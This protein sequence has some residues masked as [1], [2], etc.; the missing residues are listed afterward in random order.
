MTPADQS[1]P[2]V[3]TDGPYGEA[4]ELFGDSWILDVVSKKKPSSGQS[5][6]RWPVPA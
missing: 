2:P 1:K 6:R 4:K 3:V 5:R